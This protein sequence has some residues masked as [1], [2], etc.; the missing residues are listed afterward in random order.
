VDSIFKDFSKVFDK[1]RHRLLLDKMST[2][3]EPS[4]CQWLSSYLSGRIQPVRIDDCV[5]RDILFTSGVPQGRHL[6]Q[7]CFIWFVNEI[8][9]IF[10]IFRLTI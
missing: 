8:S 3:V 5:S 6:G 9:W 4:R 2:D 10:K 1:V 7:L